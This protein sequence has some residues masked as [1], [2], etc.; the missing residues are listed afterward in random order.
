[1]A[2]RLLFKPGFE[3]K[4]FLIP[5]ASG[6]PGGLNDSLEHPFFV[7]RSRSTKADSASQRVIHIVSASGRLKRID[8]LALR[9]SQCDDMC[10]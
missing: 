9:D 5:V 8:E 2:F 1:M 7:L 4:F 3:T 6:S 10:L